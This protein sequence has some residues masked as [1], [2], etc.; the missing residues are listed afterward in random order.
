MARR[1]SR[2]VTALS[3]ALLVVAIL[4]FLASF[5]LNPWDHYVSFND[6]FHVGVLAGSFDWWFDSRIVLFSDATNGP[7]CG[8]IIQIHFSDG[9][10]YPTF[11]HEVKWGDTC[12]VYYRYFRTSDW[13][14]WTLMVT[15]WY[16]IIF[17]AIMPTMRLLRLRSCRRV[18]HAA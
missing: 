9:T 8:S 12:G 14:L 3:T 13:T 10:A 11:E 4:L 7:Y 15:P 6:S 17:F 16:P 5:V 1:A 18:P 2:I